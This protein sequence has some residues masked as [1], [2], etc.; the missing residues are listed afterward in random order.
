VE[1]KRRRMSKDTKDGT[2]GRGRGDA[3]NKG[4]DAEGVGGLETG[5]G[6]GGGETD[7]KYREQKT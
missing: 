6:G 1:V 5:G 2:R 4:G 3:L 7:E